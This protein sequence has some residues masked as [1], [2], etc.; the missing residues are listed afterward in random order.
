MSFIA[1][2]TL[3]SFILES[4]TVH[5]SR[6]LA[7]QAVS[8]LRVLHAVWRFVRKRYSGGDAPHTFEKERVQRL[9]GSDLCFFVALLTIRRSASRF[10]GKLDK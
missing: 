6:I 10:S 5:L 2:F 3:L 1:G 4:M 7:C 8:L 9:G